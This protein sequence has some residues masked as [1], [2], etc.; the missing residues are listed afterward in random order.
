MSTPEPRSTEPRH[1]DAADTAN[2]Q[3]FMDAS[4]PQTSDDGRAFRLISLLVGVAVLAGVMYVLLF[5]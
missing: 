4:E 1:D 3:Q 2:F 5:T